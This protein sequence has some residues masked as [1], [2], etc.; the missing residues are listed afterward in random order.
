MRNKKRLRNSYKQRRHRDM[1]IKFKRTLRGK[2]MVKLKKKRK[3]NQPSGRKNSSNS[4]YKRLISIIYQQLLHNNPKMYLE[5]FT[6][7]KRR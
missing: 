1:A 2:K 7:R 4:Y 5:E 3:D 6:K